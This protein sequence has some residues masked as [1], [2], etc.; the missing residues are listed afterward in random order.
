MVAAVGDTGISSVV[1]KMII[2]TM[3][4]MVLMGLQV[5]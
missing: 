4:I 1:K 2:V 5:R 3:I